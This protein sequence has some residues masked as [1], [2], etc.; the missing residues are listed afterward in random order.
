[1]SRV[2]GVS[3]FPYLLEYTYLWGNP[4][5]FRCPAPEYFWASQSSTQFL[6]YRL[7]SIGDFPISYLWVRQVILHISR[8]LKDTTVPNLFGEFP[9][10]LT[11]AFS[12]T[13]S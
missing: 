2:A 12:V 10:F 9:F 4:S 7:I 1:M 6:L 5:F 11:F 13:S 8:K 3:K